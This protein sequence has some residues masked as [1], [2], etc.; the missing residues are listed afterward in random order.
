MVN[1]QLLYKVLGSLLFL[2][3]SLL[4]FCAGIAFYYQEDDFMAFLVS[5]LFTFSCGFIMRYLGRDA[6][7]NLSR[8]DSYLLVTVTWVVFSLFG[9]LPFLISGYI[10][11]VT[12]AFF[13]TMSCFSTTG[14]TILDNVE[15][16]PHAMLYWRTQTQWIGGLGIVFFTI[17][18]LPSMVGNGSVKVFAAEAT[19]PLRTK[20]HPRLSTMAKWIWSIYLA[21]TVACIL[22]FYFAGM[23][24]GDSINYAMTTTATGGFSTHNDSAGFFHSP[25]IEY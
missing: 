14:A 24:W 18:I 20:M 19:G 16:L 2:L 12:D 3:A 21:L 1:Y 22:S 8:R 7:N 6:D 9:M 4:L 10:G 15:G 13:E 11:N 17:A 5:M 25:A 23:G